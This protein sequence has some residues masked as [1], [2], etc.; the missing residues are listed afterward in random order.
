MLSIA[1]DMFLR[2]HHP[3][4]H[5]LLLLLCQDLAARKL[6]PRGPA[7]IEMLRLGLGP[8]ADTDFTAGLVDVAK[9]LGLSGLQARGAEG[10]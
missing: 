2:T 10:V 6:G 9:Q 1:Q 5:S 8:A 3:L 4:P 7:V